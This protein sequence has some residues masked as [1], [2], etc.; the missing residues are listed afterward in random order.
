MLS[1]GM[2]P[3]TLFQLRVLSAYCMRL[4]YIRRHPGR[5]NKIYR[6]YKHI[7]DE[8]EARFRIVRNMEAEQWKWCLEKSIPAEKRLRAA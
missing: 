7:I 1:F 4:V 5:A 6:R 8:G 2:K 3:Y